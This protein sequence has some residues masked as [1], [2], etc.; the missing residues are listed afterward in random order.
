MGNKRTYELTKLAKENITADH[1]IPIDIEGDSEAHYI[2]LADLITER[3]IYMNIGTWNMQASR[4][5]P[6]PIVVPANAISY[7][8]ESIYDDD[9]GRHNPNSIFDL[10]LSGQYAQDVTKR[11]PYNHSSDPF[12]FFGFWCKPATFG[13]RH[14]SEIVEGVTN[15]RL[16]HDY[17]TLIDSG[18]KYNGNMVTL[19]WFNPEDQ[20]TIPMGETEFIISEPTIYELKLGDIIVAPESYFDINTKVVEIFEG[21]RTENNYTYSGRYIRLSNPTKR[22]F[23][24]LTD[25]FQFIT[26]NR[27]REQSVQYALENNCTSNLNAIT[28]IEGHGNFLPTATELTKFTNES[29][30][31]GVIMIKMPL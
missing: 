28:N 2:D 22:A 10:E 21:Q 11:M 16:M 12:D 4:F 30:N 29:V 14:H 24:S 18:N 6:N 19:L 31:R 13:I 7:N 20:N 15:L 23:N 17:P 26:P 8:I 3:T 25:K 9:G 5:A 27:F 1:K